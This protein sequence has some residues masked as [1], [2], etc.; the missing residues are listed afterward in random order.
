MGAKFCMAPMTSP[1]I[2]LANS[3]KRILADHHLLKPYR[4]IDPRPSSRNETGSGTTEI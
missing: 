4:N 2:E 1:I 3:R